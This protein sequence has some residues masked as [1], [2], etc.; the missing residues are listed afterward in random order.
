MWKFLPGSAGLSS[1][2][3][4]FATAVDVGYGKPLAWYVYP[5]ED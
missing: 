3:V 1:R 4:R 2:R 5:E